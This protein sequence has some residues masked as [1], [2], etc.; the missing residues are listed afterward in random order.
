VRRREKETD[1]HVTYL[2][3]LDRSELIS[4]MRS[5]LAMVLPSICYEN[6]PLSCIEGL[7]LGLPLVVST[8]GG[9][10]ELIEEPRCGIA[11]EPTVAGISG[12]LRQIED[13]D[14]LR[15]T[16]SSNA[17]RRY[18]SFHTPERYIESYMG[19]VEEVL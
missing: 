2:G 12:A 7:S 6:A 1:G 9:L 5:A 4:E 19:T 8:M 14:R 11:C 16:F 15:S 10:P 18:E 17:L 13:D 3:Y